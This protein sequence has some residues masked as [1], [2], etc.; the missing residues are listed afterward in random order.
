MI[1]CVSIHFPTNTPALS[2]VICRENKNPFNT[3]FVI[4]RKIT[5]LNKIKHHKYFNKDERN[6]IKYETK[7]TKFKNMYETK[8]TKFKNNDK[9]ITP[10]PL[11]S[12]CFRF[13]HVSFMFFVHIIYTCRR[14]TSVSFPESTKKPVS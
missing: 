8:H 5:Q 2:Y 11:I 10:L 9:N 7:N 13:L 14:E 4:V 6:Q 12:I 3:L 1:P